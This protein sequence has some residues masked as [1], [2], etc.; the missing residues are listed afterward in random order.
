M[1]FQVEKK[2]LLKN[3]LHLQVNLGPFNSCLDQ[4]TY[5]QTFLKNIK[6]LKRLI[7]ILQLHPISMSE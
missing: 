2:K 1:L 6:I 7:E 3:C 5:Y 4:I